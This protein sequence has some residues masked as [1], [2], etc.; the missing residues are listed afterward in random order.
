MNKT[1]LSRTKTFSMI[2]DNGRILFLKLT[3]FLQG[4]LGVVLSYLAL[5]LFF[6]CPLAFHFT[7]RLPG[8]G[9]DSIGGIWYFWFFKH[10]L[11]D[12][13]TNPFAQ[14]DLVFYPIGFNISTGYDTLLATIISLP[15]QFIFKNPFIVYNILI[16]FNFVF[17][18]Y[19]SYLLAKYLTN[20]KKVSFI[21][22]IIFGFSPYMM[23]RSLGHMNLLTTGMI[24]LFI[25]IFLKT[26]K[27]PSLKSFSLSALLFLLVSLSSWQYGLFTLLFVFFSLVFLYLTSKKAILNK[28]YVINFAFFLILSALLTLPFALPMI[29]NKVSSKIPLPTNGDATHYAADALSYLTPPPASILF[30]KFISKDY[31]G[32]LSTNSTESTTYLGVFEIIFILY[33][34]FAIRKNKFEKIFSENIYWII[35]AFIFFILSLGPLLKIGG[36]I[37]NFIL[38]YYFIFYLPFFDLAK[39][40]VRMS[41]FVMLFVMIIFSVFLK[42]YLEKNKLHRNMILLLTALIII[43]ERATFPYQIEKIGISPFYNKISEDKNDY[44]ILDLPANTKWLQQPLYNFYQVTHQKKIIVGAMGYTSFSSN[45]YSWIEQNDFVNKSSCALIT[46]KK[47]PDIKIS[48]TKSDR[49]KMIR[50]LKDVKIKYVVFHKNIIANFESHGFDCQKVKDN[51]EEFFINEQPIYEDELIIVYQI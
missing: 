20:D 27:N 8:A 48:K 12:L 32:S 15:L 11:F 42:A 37:S 25:L 35:L 4:N 45:S 24:P 44:T 14:S 49:D 5:A 29:L 10:N 38:P 26:L 43:A 13:H 1:I 30:G 33:F 17:S 9:A 28:Q 2:S 40:P 6:T 47:T 7:D 39:E 22:G 18:S 31:F 51:I 41:I 50:E 16:I 3:S 23:A 46:D 19:A 21:A 36:H 34:F